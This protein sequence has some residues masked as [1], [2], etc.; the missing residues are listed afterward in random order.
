VRVD[1]QLVFNTLRQRLD[2][3]LQGLGLAYMPEDIAA[4][5]IA[6]GELVRV[7]DDWCAPFAGYNLY[8]PSRRHASP[9]F[10]LLVEA[11]QFKGASELTRTMGFLRPR[12]VTSDA[13]EPAHQRHP[14]APLQA[15]FSGD[16][17]E[18][19]PV[20]QHPET[21]RLING[22]VAEVTPPIDHV[23]VF[24]RT[25]EH[26]C[27]FM[28]AMG[29]FRQVRAGWGADEERPPVFR[30]R[31]AHACDPNAVGEGPARSEFE[32]QGVGQYLR[33]PFRRRCL[34]DRVQAIKDSVERTV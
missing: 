3:A 27:E 13:E 25:A 30:R 6:S 8:Y 10:S 22:G 33:K 20:G 32:A 28:P 17:G 34:R 16:E 18:A 14:A 4:P 23:T 7:L 2:S 19:W 9:A 29:V 15:P 21:M 24:D 1:G 12:A 31:G 26:A 11:L 5:Y